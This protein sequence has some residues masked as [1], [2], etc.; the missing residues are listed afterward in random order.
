MTAWTRASSTGDGDAAGVVEVVQEVFEG[1]P[2]VDAVHV[3]EEDGLILLST[4][5][6]ASLGG[7]E[8]ISRGDVIVY[9][10]AAGVALP[11]FGVSNFA[12]TENVNAVH[13]V[14]VSEPGHAFMLVAGFALLRLLVRRH[15]LR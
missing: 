8:N 12:S 5:R 4:S 14:P 1:S 11:F 13:A 9:D 6:T 7:M 15:R 10:P 2:N 3:F